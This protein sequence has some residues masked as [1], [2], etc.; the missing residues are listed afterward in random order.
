MAISPSTASFESVLQMNRN[1]AYI[2]IMADGIIKLKY[3]ISKIF[4]L[5][6]VHN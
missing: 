5:K 2:Q 4:H 6:L 3:A 1:G